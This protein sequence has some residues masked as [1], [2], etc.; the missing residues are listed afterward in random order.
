MNKNVNINEIRTD[1][2]TQKRPMCPDTLEDYTEELKDGK[3]PF[4]P[5]VVFKDGELYILADGFHR[6]MAAL[7]AGMTQV[8]CIVKEGGL[9][10]ANFYAMGCNQLNGRRMTRGQQRKCVIECLTAHPELSRRQISEITRVAVTTVLRIANELIEE[11]GEDEEAE[12]KSSQPKTGVGKRPEKQ[13]DRE[14]WFRRWEGPFGSMVRLLD[15]AVKNLKDAGNPAF[16]RI[17][18]HL[19]ALAEEVQTW[20]L[21]K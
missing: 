10:E 6:L 16:A 2:N 9:K 19:N 12:A 20:L 13:Y 14:T 7:N 4:P 11:S 15:E 18:N 5:L 1:L 17:E 8:P 21:E 3:W